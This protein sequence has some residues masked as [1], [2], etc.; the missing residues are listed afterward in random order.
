MTIFGTANA[1]PARLYLPKAT[2]TWSLEGIFDGPKKS[3][4][5]SLTGSIKSF[6]NGK[7]GGGSNAVLYSI[8][9]TDTESI[10]IRRCFNETNHIFA[11]GRDITKTVM[12]VSVMVFLGESCDGAGNH[13]IATLH[14]KYDETRVSKSKESKLIQFDDV[15][16]SGF[17]ISMHIGGIDPR[18]S[19]FIAEFTYILDIDEQ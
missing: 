10:D 8:G 17:L 13:T 18:T 5:K 19:S 4:K 11:F 7:K 15:V 14:K 9:L 1:K 12:T 2:A 3:D 16:A 6:N